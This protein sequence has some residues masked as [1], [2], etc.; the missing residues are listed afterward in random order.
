MA[1]F[2]T[3][4]V[5]PSTCPST[6][7]PVRLSK[8][9]GSA[10]GSPRATAAATIA[11]PNGC[12]LRRSTDAARR[13]RDD[14]SVAHDLLHGGPSFRHGSGLVEHHRIEPP[15]SLQRLAAFDQDAELRA[16]AGRDHHGG[17]NR[18]PHGA[19][20]GDDQH[21]DRGDQGLEVRRL[22]SEHEPQ[23]E[24]RDRDRDHHRHEDGGDPVGETLDRR[25]R[26]LRLLHQPDDAGEDG[27]RAH[28][29]HPERAARRSD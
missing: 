8:P 22:G 20:T 17:R 6:P 9:C 5:R 14:S 7:R 16:A 2:P 19:G 23:H 1:R 4:T 10:R 27:I 21:R 15:A 26:S 25:L 28:P 3:A 24:G 29:L 12:S 13:S 18:E 11:S